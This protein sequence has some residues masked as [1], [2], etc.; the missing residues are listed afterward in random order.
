MQI[1]RFSVSNTIAAAVGSVIGGLLADRFGIRKMLAFVYALTTV[2]ALYLAIQIS[3]SG[4][5]SVP[6]ELFYGAIMLH[7]LI[8][9]AAFGMHAAVFMGLTNPVVAA[10]QFTAFMGMTNLAV[11]IANYWQGMV[12][13]RIDY[14]MVLYLDSL[15]VVVPLAIIPF[16]KSREEQAAVASW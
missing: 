8:F 15:F 11:V 13:E 12:G 1:A 5:T 10:T 14:A 3:A 16:L 6:L 7:G 2:P 4:L 9:G